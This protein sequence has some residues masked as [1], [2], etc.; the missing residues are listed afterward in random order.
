[1]AKRQIVLPG[2][3]DPKRAGLRIDRERDRIANAL[4][5]LH[6]MRACRF[7]HGDGG[8]RWIDFGARAA[9]AAAHR[10]IARGSGG[11]VE[12]AA[13]VRYRGR[14]VNVAVG[15]RRNGTAAYVGDTTNLRRLS[16]TAIGDAPYVMHRVGVVSIVEDPGTAGCR[17]RSIRHGDI[18]GEAPPCRSAS[19]QRPKGI[20]SHP[21][22]W[23]ISLDNPTA[24][25]RAWARTPAAN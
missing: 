20:D 8:A 25:G 1:M 11:D 4:R 10:C 9:P 18:N 14:R 6:K 23:L 5:A 19:S 15:A 13:G 3:A 2:V 12:H 17:R 21:R 24:A 16:L 7:H 22:Y